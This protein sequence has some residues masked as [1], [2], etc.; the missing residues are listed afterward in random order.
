MTMSCG[1]ARRLLW[2]DASPRA[3]T[4]EVEAAQG[5]LATC[6]EC[7]LFLEEMRRLARLTHDVGPRPQAP[8]EVRDR[9]FR[10]VAR[11]RTGV[12]GA[13][14]HSPRRWAALAVLALLIVGLAVEWRSWTN[15]VADPI[16]GLADDHMRATRGDGVVSGDSV[17]VS[18]WLAARLPFAM[19]VPA[20]PSLALRG[21]RLCVMEGQR[22]G[23]VEYSAEGRTVS[24]FVV[25][26]WHPPAP[27]PV[28]G[29]LH[30]AKREGYHIVS[31]REPGLV[32]ALVGD[33]P[34]ARLVELARL[35][36]SKV[37]AFLDAGTRRSRRA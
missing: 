3:V 30:R 10:A 2:P 22:G 12:P 28:Q 34:E 11:A 26:D 36:M 18:R 9:L 8:R 31:W 1:R 13:R 37:V 19:D 21:A 16:A 25:P 23:V 27:P 14:T 32:H 4:P 6:E 5:H 20:L 17:L 29:E 35:C 7:R 15:R 33:L 24:Y